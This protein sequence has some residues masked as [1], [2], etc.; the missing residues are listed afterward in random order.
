ML[1]TVLT[2]QPTV[3]QS[4]LSALVTTLSPLIEKVD[5]DG[6]SIVLLIIAQKVG[7]PIELVK[8]ASTDAVFNPSVKSPALFRIAQVFVGVSSSFQLAAQ[9]INDTF[10]SLTVAALKS[11]LPSRFNG[12]CRLLEQVSLSI[13]TPS[14]LPFIGRGVEMIVERFGA[15][16][17]FQSS[18]NAMARALCA[19]VGRSG[20][21]QQHLVLFRVLNKAAPSSSSDACFIT[22]VGVL[23]AALKSSSDSIE[24]M[25]RFPD[26][27]FDSIFN[28]SGYGNGNPFKY[29]RLCLV[30]RLRRIKSVKESEKLIKK[31]IDIWKTSLPSY[32]A[33]LQVIEW[34]NLIECHFSVDKAFE[35]FDALLVDVIKSAGFG[36]GFPALLRL[37]VGNREKCKDCK[38]FVKLLDDVSGVLQKKSH[39]EAFN[40][41]KNLPE[42]I[43]DKEKE[44]CKELIKMAFSENE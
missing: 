4:F 6:L 39:I 17:S 3:P 7:F 22:F 32:A 20:A 1:A 13:K 18:V 27:F 44:K 16:S 11:L 43:E 24:I 21:A 8:F 15:F 26:S 12:G 2:V 19:F 10:S 31:S 37:F 34:W 35:I 29:A 40:E 14:I 42:K 23:L 28:Q 33:M 38:E 30:E 9:K 41:M 5:V 25:K 36:A